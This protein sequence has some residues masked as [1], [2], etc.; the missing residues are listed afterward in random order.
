MGYC[1]GGNLLTALGAYLAKKPAPFT[2]ESMTLIATIIDFTKIGDL[3]IFMDDENL[4]YIEHNLALKGFVDP[5]RLKSIFSMLRPKDLLWSFFI[6]NYLLGQVPPAFDFLYWNSDAT[7]VPEALHRDVLRKCF[8]ENLFMTPGGLQI[9]DV[10]IDMQNIKTPTF[11]LSTIEDHIAPWKSSYPAVHQFK[12]P[13]EFV[14][15]GSGHVVGVMNHPDRHKYGYFTNPAFPSSPEEWLESALKNEGSWWPF[16]DAW[17]RLMSG[18]KI[19]PKSGKSLGPAP[20]E[21]VKEV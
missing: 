13:L 17:L 6:K 5:E 12:G 16:W 19:T 4:E 7:R 10:P 3:K 18:E 20:G 9:K 21:Y 14:L 8:R 15:A 2:L 11:F 1:I